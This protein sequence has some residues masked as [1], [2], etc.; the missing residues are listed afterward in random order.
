MKN[1]N[2]Y[3]TDTRFDSY[4]GLYAVFFFNLPKLFQIIIRKRGI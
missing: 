4:K 3:T 2:K 1:E